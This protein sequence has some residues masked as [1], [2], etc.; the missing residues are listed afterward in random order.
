MGKIQLQ[1]KQK[2]QIMLDDESNDYYIIWQSPVIISLGK[3]EIEAL[4]DFK[5]P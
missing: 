3:T 1:N 5:A 2:M 4:K